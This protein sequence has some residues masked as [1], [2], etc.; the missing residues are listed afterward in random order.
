MKTCCTQPRFV[1]WTAVFRAAVGIGFLAACMPKLERP[2]DFLGAVYNYSL[3]DPWTGLFIAR[4]IP[5][6]ELTIGAC[7]L[8]GVLVVGALFC[9]GVL[10]LVFTTAEV[11]VLCR[12]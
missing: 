3:V 7:L 5:W 10:L 12:G 11:A 4:V 6:F 2:Y 9:G 8:A 1:R